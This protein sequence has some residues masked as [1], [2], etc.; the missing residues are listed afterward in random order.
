MSLANRSEDVTWW[1][2]FLP[3]PFPLTSLLPSLPPTPLMF[4]TMRYSRHVPACRTLRAFGACARSIMISF[5]ISSESTWNSSISRLRLERMLEIFCHKNGMNKAQ[6]VKDMTLTAIAA[7]AA[8]RAD[9]SAEKIHAFFNNRQ[10]QAELTVL[11][12]ENSIYCLHF[13]FKTSYSPAQN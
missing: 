8:N 12:Y 5:Q 1:I 4:K 3:P 2:T 9:I 11:N 10:Q 6:Q 7:V 13:Y